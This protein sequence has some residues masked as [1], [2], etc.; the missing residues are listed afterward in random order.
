MIQAPARRLIALGLGIALACGCG[1]ALPP[2]PSTVPVDVPT[3]SISPAVPSRSA[4][5]SEPPATAVTWSDC[6]GGFQ[7]GSVLVPRDY[8]H[9]DAGS[10][11]MA[12]IRL[13]ALDRVHRIGSLV[14]NPGGPGVS[15]V[16][17]VRGGAGSLFSKEIRQRFDIV[18]FDPRGV[19]LSSPV[20]CIDDLE[21]FLATDSTPDTPV[22]LRALLAGEQAFAEGCQRRNADLL[23]F[24]GTENVARD[25]DRLRAS[26]GD[27]KL[28]YVGFSYGTL[29]GSLYAQAFPDRIRALVLDGV[30]DPTLDLAHLSEGQAIAFEAALNRFVADCA[31]HAACAFHHGGKPGPALDALMRRIEAKPL[32]VSFVNDRRKVGPTYA[33][34][35]VVGALYARE[36]WP[37]LADA[38]AEAER[39]DGS[40]L[41]LLSDPLNGRRSDGGY[42]NLVDANRAV[43]CLDFPGP[44]DPAAYEAEAKLWARKA[45]RLGA[46][47]AYSDIGCAFW[48]IP[49]GR[50]PTAVSAPGAPPIVLI[51]STGDPATP[52]AWAVAL[53]RQLSSSVLITRRGEGH[54]G[55]PFSAC[56]RKAA[57][58]YLLD[59]T[60]PGQGLTCAS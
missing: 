54:T 47:L 37:I 28:T 26:L 51:G 29:I 48:P 33:W 18:G 4:P 52:Y 58:A 60:V 36:G 42:S 50:H 9:P 31:R 30:V 44:R 32:P 21:H 2:S 35:G 57:D 55:Y 25:L 1:P 39:G 13:S 53:S 6:G 43:S 20:R 14:I 46:L 7:C 22:E 12:V 11:S 3:A 59:L 19:N 23:P 24:L 38:L 10:L 40:L 34:S 15:G 27:S 5:P 41:L 16:D 45:P 8:A 56:V 49:P 17:F